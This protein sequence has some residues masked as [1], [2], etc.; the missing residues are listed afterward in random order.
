M[1]P[2]PTVSCS[3]FTK[4]A[5]PH[6]WNRSQKGLLHRQKVRIITVRLNWVMLTYEVTIGSLLELPVTKIALFTHLCDLLCF[7]VINH[8][9]RSKFFIL[10]SSVTL[11]VTAL[12]RA[13]PKHIRLG[14]HCDLFL[15]LVSQLTCLTLSC[16]SVFPSLRRSER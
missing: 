14:K 5:S 1:T 9:F 15:H 12:L 2:M 13:R 7:F 10:S 8:S 6:C 4:M 16:T 3:T 11:K